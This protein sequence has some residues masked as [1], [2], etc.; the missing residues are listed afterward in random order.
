MLTTINRQLS[1]DKVYNEI[2]EIIDRDVTFRSYLNLLVSVNINR[3]MNKK[4]DLDLLTDE[5]II[6]EINKYILK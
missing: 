3:H 2:D 1:I 4:Y 5:E 6:S